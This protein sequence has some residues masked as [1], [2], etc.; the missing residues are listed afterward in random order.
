MIVKLSQRIELVTTSEDYW[1]LTT[2][3]L[4]CA[5]FGTRA[6]SVTLR[7]EIG[8]CPHKDVKRTGPWSSHEKQTT[9]DSDDDEQDLAPLREAEPALLD[10]YYLVQ[11]SASIITLNGWQEE[12]LGKTEQ[13]KSASE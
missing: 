10:K 13:A 5:G 8:D 9:F 3:I 2:S 4:L 1:N 7:R 11:G 12:T 6:R